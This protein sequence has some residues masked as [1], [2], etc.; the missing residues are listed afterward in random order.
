MPSMSSQSAPQPASP[1]HHGWVNVF[2]SEKY[3]TDAIGTGKCPWDPE[4]ERECVDCG[5]YDRCPQ[6]IE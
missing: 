6:P 3:N 1:E 4:G 2:F 5:P